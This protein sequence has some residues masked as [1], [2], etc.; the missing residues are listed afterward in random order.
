MVIS[1]KTIEKIRQI[2]NKHYN[3]LI[4]SVLGND[5]LSQQELNE[6]KNAGYDISNKDSLLSLAYHHNFINAPIDKISPTSVGDM[7][8]QQSVTGIKPIGEAHDFTVD[9]LNETT[10]QYIN[11]LKLDVGS[12]VEGFIRQNNVDYKFNALS[13]LDRTDLA[14]RLVKESSVGK[15]KQL[16]RDSSGDANRDWNRIALTELGNA[17][18]AGSVDRIVSDNMNK[19]TD[20][21]YVY[22]IIVGDSITCKFCRQFYG[23]VGNAPKIYKL[24]TL[25]ANGSNIGKN[26][27]Q[28]RPV[29]GSTHPNTRTSQIVELKPGFK[30]LPG[31]R[32]TYIGLDKWKDYIHENLVE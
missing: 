11:K 25:L 26:T 1:Q 30:V 31:G 13:N 27:S 15:V 28:W 8:S 24:S 9:H 3:R 12:R 2:I 17:I 32:A 29:T 7:K 19:D 5:L 10:K 16:L 6:L 14:D 22:R 18:G 23:D 4:I 20:D 21:I